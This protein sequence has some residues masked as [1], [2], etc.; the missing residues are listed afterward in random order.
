MI[1]HLIR[2]HQGSVNVI[3][4]QGGAVQAEYR[5]DPWGGRLDPETRTY[6]APGE[7]PELM[8]GRGY[9]GHEHLPEYGLIHMNARLYDPQTGRFLSPDPYV[10]DPANTQ[11][12]NRYAHVLNDPLRYTDPSGELMRTQV[13]IWMS[14]LRIHLYHSCG[15]RFHML[16]F[17]HTQPRNLST[18]P[19]AYV[20]KKLYF[21]TFFQKR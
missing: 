11:S 3:T 9:T 5:Y 10:Q 7:E 12:Y 6:Y 18:S 13:V 16:P 17:P 19:L 15:L 20:P 2:D 8:F 21:S 14:F 1:C 4:D